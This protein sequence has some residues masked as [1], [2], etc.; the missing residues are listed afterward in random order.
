MRRRAH[1]SLVQELTDI[2]VNLDPHERRRAKAPLEPLADDGTRQQFLTATERALEVSARASPRS[3]SPP[4]ANLTEPP[5]VRGRDASNPATRFLANAGTRNPV[6]R[7]QAW[8]PQ[9]S[10]GSLHSLCWSDL[11]CAD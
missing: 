10:K 8:A 1:T 6:A 4:A 11:N 9:F 2:G 3:F 5:A 7:E